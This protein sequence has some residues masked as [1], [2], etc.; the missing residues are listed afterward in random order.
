MILNIDLTGKELVVTQKP[1]P[2]L[3][4]H[5]DQRVSRE[6]SEPMWATQVVVT[7]PSGGEIITITTEGAMP[8]LAVGDVVDV[9]ALVAIPW[10]SNG[11]SGMAF[12]AE[13]IKPSY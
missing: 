6:S 2:K 8:E 4:Q 3:D 5:G 11:R 1:R 10:F 9:A 13:E 7:D 12:R